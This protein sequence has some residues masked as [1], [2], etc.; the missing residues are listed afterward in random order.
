MKHKLEFIKISDDH[1][2][3]GVGF[4]GNIF[5]VLNPKIALSERVAFGTR[6]CK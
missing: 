5:I 4:A 3:A 1:E 2:F 6:A